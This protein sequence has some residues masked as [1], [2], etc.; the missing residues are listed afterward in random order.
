[1][2]GRLRAAFLFF[3]SFRLIES[4][5]RLKQAMTKIDL[6]SKSIEQLWALHEEIASILIAKMAAEKLKLEQRL[7]QIE[8]K[9]ANRKPERRAYPKVYPR[10]RNPDPPHQ[11]W[12][13][14]GLQPGWVRILLA[15]GKSLENLRIRP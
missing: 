1:L 6:K 2:K 13:G 4:R 3:Y 12:S 7:D 9:S 11:T 10:F 5:G 14:R 15:K 8:K